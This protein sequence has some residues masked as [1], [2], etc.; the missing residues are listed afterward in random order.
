MGT[1]F[2]N[3][4][5]REYTAKHSITVL[6]IIKSIIPILI[7]DIYLRQYSDSAWS[8]LMQHQNLPCCHKLMDICRLLSSI[9]TSYFINTFQCKSFDTINSAIILYLIFN[10]N[11]EKKI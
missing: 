4:K 11:K 7:M 10:R 2:F 6:A 8:I 5:W 9:M 3:D 1:E